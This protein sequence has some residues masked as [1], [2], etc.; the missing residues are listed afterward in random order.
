MMGDERMC[1]E[2]GWMGERVCE[3]MMMMVAARN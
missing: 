3:K 1:E 2:G